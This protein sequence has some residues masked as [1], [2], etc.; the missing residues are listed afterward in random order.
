MTGLHCSISGAR[1]ILF[2]PLN[3]S[4]QRQPAIIGSCCGLAKKPDMA[5]RER[6]PSTKRI[7]TRQA[8]RPSFSAQ[9]KLNERRYMQIRTDKMT[10]RNLNLP[11]SDPS[12]VRIYFT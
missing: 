5:D 11:E 4:S 1:F 12:A 2:R 6:L 9:F 8:T 10:S 7:G 3:H